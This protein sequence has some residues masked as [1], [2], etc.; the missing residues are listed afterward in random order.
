MHSFNNKVIHSGLTLPA[1]MTAV[2]F[3]AAFSLLTAGC[4]TTDNEG[5]EISF[6][7]NGG[8]LL[9]PP[10]AVA[11]AGENNGEADTAASDG[12]IFTA[13]G[14]PILRTGYWLNIGVT[15]GD[16]AE[17]APVEVQVSDK[18]EITLP[19]IGKVQCDGMTIYSLR[20][21]LATRYG[22]YLK[23]PEVTVSFVVKDGY[24]SPWGKVLVCGRVRG[25]GWVPIPATRDLTLS[26]AI[27]LA[28]GF[29][30]SARRDNIRVSRRLED[31]TMKFFKVNLEEIGKKGKMENDLLLKPE[32]VIYVYESN[33]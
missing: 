28:G 16:R 27:Q 15:V 21:Y 19:M 33:L 14:E 22:D 2:V 31:G 12:L 30:P 29:G 1:V 32:D 25:E 23:N 9:L 5:T 17:F 7:D 4:A 18:N 20:S 11:T 3:C 24:S 13:K 26:R 8:M 10:A 6:D